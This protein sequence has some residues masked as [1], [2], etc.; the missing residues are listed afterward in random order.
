MWHVWNLSG[1][2]MMNINTRN[3]ACAPWATRMA[4]AALLLGCKDGSP[5]DAGQEQRNGAC[6]PIAA[7][8]SGGTGSAGAEG[9]ATTDGGIGAEAGAP[10]SVQ[11][12]VGDPCED[13]TASSDC[14]GN[15]P[16]CAPLPSGSVCTQIL[17]LEGEVNAGACPSGWTC[18]QIRP[19]PD[20]SVCL[21]F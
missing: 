7:A 18:L 20:P 1:G 10:A 16:I 19:M 11:A 13:T 3:L 15:A 8:G 14:G 4:L 6:I 17:C 2:S 12:E 9:G 21:N 5:C